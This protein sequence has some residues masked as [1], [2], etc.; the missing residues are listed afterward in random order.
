MQHSKKISTAVPVHVK[1]AHRGNRSFP[2]LILFLG[3]RSREQVN[4]TL[5][6]HRSRERT[7]AFIYTTVVSRNEYKY[8]GIFY[9]H[10]ELLHVSA[11]HVAV[12]RDVKYKG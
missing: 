10:N 1:K 2:P 12:F 5:R 4:F 11:N 3:S 6:P 9:V 8:T 7:S